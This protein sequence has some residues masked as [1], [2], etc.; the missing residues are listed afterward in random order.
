MIRH[1]RQSP[2]P[3]LSYHSLGMLV[4]S[5]IGAMR[6]REHFECLRTYFGLI[7][8]VFYNLELGVRGYFRL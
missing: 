1:L 3:N 6:S 8:M 5:A 7:N 4:A 2:I